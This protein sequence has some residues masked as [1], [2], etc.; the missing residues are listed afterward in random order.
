MN[1]IRH[2]DTVISKPQLVH[3]SNQ[4]NGSG[5][6]ATGA[7]GLFINASVVIAFSSAA[8]VGLPL[9]IAQNGP[10]EVVRSKNV[11]EG[12]SRFYDPF[13]NTA[14]DSQEN[15]ELLVDIRQIYGR[16]KTAFGW[17]VLDTAKVFQV[18]RKTLYDWLSSEELPTP[19]SANLKR[20][21]KLDTIASYVSSKLTLPVGTD[22]VLQLTGTELK[23]LLEADEINVNDAEKWIDEL[24]RRRAA[25]GAKKSLSERLAAAGMKPRPGSEYEDI[26]L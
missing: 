22:S 11:V 1:I 24:A 15:G 12:S 7:L 5:N 23:A 14:P 2:T 6:R 20:A 9:H 18:N 25:F 13:Q 10:T 21:I 3:A 17:S 16:V 8:T 19:Q 4:T 26:I